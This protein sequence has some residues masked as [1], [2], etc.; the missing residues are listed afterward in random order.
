M[1]E[2]FTMLDAIMNGVKFGLTLTAAYTTYTFATAIVNAVAA[3]INNSMKTQEEEA[4][5]E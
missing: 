5:E 4:S 1:E 3:N 2:K